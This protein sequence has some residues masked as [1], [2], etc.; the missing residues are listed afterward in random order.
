M[1]GFNYEKNKVL[2]PA[3]CRIWLEYLK[4]GDSYV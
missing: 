2:K 3:F 1:T 4:K